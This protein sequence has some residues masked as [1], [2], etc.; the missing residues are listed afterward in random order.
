VSF[1]YQWE[2]CDTNGDNCVDIG[3]A[4]AST[5]TLV[6]DDIGTT[7]RVRVS[8]GAVTATSSPTNVIQ[9]PGSPPPPPPGGAWAWDATA[10]TPR[11]NSAAMASGPV[12]SA[13]SHTLFAAS[14]AMVEASG[15]LRTITIAGTPYQ[16]ALPSTV[17]PGHST[18]RHLTVRDT[19]RSLEA[20]MWQYTP[21]LGKANGGGQFTLGLVSEPRPGNADAAR[22]PLRRGVVTPD[23]VAN[24]VRH[25]LV[26]SIAQ[27]KIHTGAGVYPA[28]TDFG[29]TGGGDTPPFGAWFRLP[30]ATV[31]PSMDVLSTY[32][33][34]CLIDY[35]MFL[36]DIGSDLTIYGLDAVNQGGTQHD[37]AAAGVTLVQS[38]TPGLWY[39]YL[40]GSIP[41]ATLEA[42]EPPT[43]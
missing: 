38:S 8:D 4:T 36:R 9:D 19:G 32:I 28:D 2:R 23:D 1:T 43:P 11:A 22:F 16:I 18:D 12:A 6:A 42:L 10:A 30:P 20:D 3:G 24:D 37:W 41:W 34:H 15:S 31:V 14:V 5:Y 40:S 25:P 13:V 39:Q 7:I 35:G 27:S 26:F 17:Q 33:C 21:S 29:G